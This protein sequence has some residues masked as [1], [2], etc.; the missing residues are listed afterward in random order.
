[1][2][3]KKKPGLS[4]VSS[5]EMDLKTACAHVLSEHLN[6]IFKKAMAYVLSGHLNGN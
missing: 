3:M 4:F 5:I 6:E 2:E 1:M